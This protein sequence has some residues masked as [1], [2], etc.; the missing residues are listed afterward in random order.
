MRMVTTHTCSSDIGRGRPYTSSQRPPWGPG[1]SPQIQVHSY[2]ESLV[3]NEIHCLCAC[4]LEIPRH[5]N[6]TSLGC[7]ALSPAC[8]LL[9]F[10]A[11][12]WNMESVLKPALVAHAVTQGS[13]GWHIR[14]ADDWKLV[15]AHYSEIASLSFRVRPGL[16]FLCFCFFFLRGCCHENHPELLLVNEVA[17]WCGD[18]LPQSSIPE[19]GQETQL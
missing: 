17:A 1:V 10:C 11:H 18:A 6:P 19:A 13:G 15:W 5:V 12:T 3:R 16:L 7:A 8:L 9:D 4:L 2:S 14:I